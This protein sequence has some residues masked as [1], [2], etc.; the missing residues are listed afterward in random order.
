MNRKPA[1]SAFLLE[2][3]WVCGFF[4]VA[5]CIFV[6]AFAKADTMSRGARNLN[7]AVTAAETALEDTFAEYNNLSADGIGQKDTRTIYLDRNWQVTGGALPTAGS[8][9]EDAAFSI[10]VTSRPNG[11]L[12]EVT[13]EVSSIKG[14][15]IYTLNGAHYMPLSE[16]G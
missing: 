4:A 16:K 7:Q 5:S 2:M 10:I 15:S 13:A 6:L 1:S 14:E 9:P 12:L 11:S 8:A 3:L